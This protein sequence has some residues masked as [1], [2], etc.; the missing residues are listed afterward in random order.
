[1]IMVVVSVLMGRGT[2]LLTTWLTRIATQVWRN[3]AR[4][5][6]SLDNLDNFSD[7]GIG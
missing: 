5:Y 1:M 2:K 3:M 7:K 4:S 6:K